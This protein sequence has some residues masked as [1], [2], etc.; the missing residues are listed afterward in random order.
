MGLIAYLLH[1]N[2]FSVTLLHDYDCP[3]SSAYPKPVQMDLQPALAHGLATSILSGEN[4]GAL[5]FQHNQCWTWTQCSSDLGDN[6][7]GSDWQ[8]TTLHGKHQLQTLASLSLS[9]L[10]CISFPACVADAHLFA[11]CCRWVQRHAGS[12]FS[13]LMLTEGCNESCTPDCC[14]TPEPGVCQQVMSCV[15]TMLLAPLQGHP[16][17]VHVNLQRKPSSACSACQ[18]SGTY[19]RSKQGQSQAANAPEPA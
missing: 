15:L 4:L 13:M 8:A 18:A 12:I 5:M 7:F 14:C 1:G 2:L 10:L 9:A 16:V 3:Q 11:V 6:T 17:D 19:L